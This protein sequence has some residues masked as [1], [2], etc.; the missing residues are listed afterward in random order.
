VNINVPYTRVYVRDYYILK[1]AKADSFTPGYW[2]GCA[3]VLHEQ[4]Q[5]HVF[6]DCGA[7]YSNLPLEA[8]SI[9]PTVAPALRN[10][11]WESL[12]ENISSIQF[13]FLRNMQ[14]SVKTDPHADIY[15]G[16]YL[17]TIDTHD[18][19]KLSDT[20]DQ[21][22]MEHVIALDHGP[23]I[24]YPNYRIRWID[25][26]LVDDEKKHIADSLK[27]QSTRYYGQ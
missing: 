8:L 13:D 7:T 9:E 4:L 20:P 5:C 22:K 3:A 16:T 25:A 17:F 14:C 23:I 2:Y 12:G 10:H 27:V 26:A 6:L 24:A 1:D 19:G 21:H 18:R 15:K 11:M